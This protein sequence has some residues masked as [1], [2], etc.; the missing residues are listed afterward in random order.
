VTIERGAAWG[1]PGALPEGSA[2]V[3]SD[4]EGRAAVEPRR[5][6]GE[7]LPALGLLGGDLC[8]TIGGRGD[9]GRL[10]T[11]AAMRLP[12]DLGSVL[13]D[14]RQHWFVAHLV[15]RRSWWQGRVVA[16]MNAQYIGHW[17]VAPRAHPADGLLDIVD[18][19]ASMRLRERWQAWR[20]LRLGTHVPHPAIAVERVGAWQTTFDPPRRVWLDGMPMGDVRN[21]SVRV[22]PDALLLVV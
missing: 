16:V 8:R 6:S 10:R 11:D 14:G 22:E 12:A 2:V 9:R 15:A 1:A 18:V 13:L 7:A 3:T 4:A 19:S 21:L 20:R 17:D 5:R